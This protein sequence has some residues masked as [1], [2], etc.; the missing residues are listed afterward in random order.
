MLALQ[1]PAALDLVD[2]PELEPFEFT[3]AEV[4][5]VLGIVARTGYTGEPGVEIMVA[6]DKV[7]LLWDALLAARARPRPGWARATRSGS[8]SAIRST[9]TTSR[10][11]APRSRRA[12]AG[13]ARSTARSSSAPPALRAQREQG[14][15]DRLVAFRM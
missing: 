10:R 14:G 13:S 5:G 12:W 11:P 4:C 7:G 3:R 6:P 1:G 9:A 2:L 15:Y 8:R